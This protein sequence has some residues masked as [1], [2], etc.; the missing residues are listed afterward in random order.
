MKYLG[1][2]ENYLI[3][4]IGDAKL[5]PYNID[6]EL[7]LPTPLGPDGHNYFFNTD[8]GYRYSINIME[9]MTEMHISPNDAEECSIVDDLDDFYE[10]VI[11][12]SFFPFTGD[13]EDVYHTYDDKVITNRGELFRIMA[14]LK[15]VV[16]KYLSEN[17]NVQY[18]FIG[19]QRGEKQG[20][21]EQRDR[22]YITYFKKLKPEWETDRIYCDF[23]G[24]TYYL[25]KVK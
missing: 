19:G 7:T 12:I 2:F 15:Y 1:T 24:E 18:I 21:K 5:P 16:E 4:E 8:S 23:M 17:P 22:L 20:D 11:G 3:L 6:N 14:T 13:D 10:N 9:G 25:V